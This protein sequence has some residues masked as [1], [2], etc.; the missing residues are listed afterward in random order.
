MTQ[1]ILIVEDEA[2]IRTLMQYNIEK[3]GY[4]TD[5][6]SDGL[7]ALNKINHNDYVLI[8]LDI[9][10][11]KV[12]GIEI[13]KIMRKQGMTTPVLMVSAKG[14]EEDIIT[15]LNVGADDYI[16][17]PFSPKE[18]I[19][20]IHAVLRRKEYER[21]AS[22]KLQQVNVTTQD[23]ERS[24]RVGKLEIFPD[25]YEAYC[26]G[27]VLHLTRKEYEL[28]HYFMQNENIILSRDQLLNAVWDY[29]FVGD[30]RIVDVHVS[31][32]REKIEVDSK[33]PQYIKTVH[34][35]GYKLENPEDNNKSK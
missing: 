3:V 9:M 6:A 13:C 27:K 26:D 15:G 8:I 18:L 1:T 7:E 20:R 28:L 11:P 33:K 29:E 19:A 5:V 30:T 34:G 32:L 17:K 21:E 24:L 14:E 23:A 2:S 31:R 22:E 35:F 4:Q 10:L 25:K 12:D 16:T